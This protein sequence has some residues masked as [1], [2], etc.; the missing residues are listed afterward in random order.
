M[1]HE[2]RNTCGTNVQIQRVSSTVRD[3]TQIDVFVFGRFERHHTLW[4]SGK[5]TDWATI[6]TFYVRYCY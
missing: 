4:V 2:K 6:A 5:T 3:K 1:G